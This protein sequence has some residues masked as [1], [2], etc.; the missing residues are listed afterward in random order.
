MSAPAAPGV[1]LVI[2][3]YRRERVLV[4]TVRLMLALD[5]TPDEI[6]IVDQT[7]RHEPDTEAELGALEKAGRIRW[8]RIEKPSIPH[9]MNVG[10]LEARHEI[11]L[12]TDDDVVPDARLIAAHLIAHEDPGVSVVAGRVYQLWDRRDRPSGAFFTADRKL[13]ATEFI[14]CNVSMKRSPAL[15]TGG[16]DEN[17][18]KAAYRYEAEF[19]WRSR[20]AGRSM[21]YEPD[22]II[23]HLKTTA[24]GTRSHGQPWFHPGHGV[25]EHYFLIRTRSL[26]G[27]IAGSSRRIARSVMTRRHLR[28][29]W[30]IPVTLAAEMTA[31]LWALLLALRGPRLLAISSEPPA[32][33]CHCEEPEATKQS[34]KMATL[35]R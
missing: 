35:L 16:F 27:T 19:S 15:A 13:P 31:F 1:T 8:I 7:P 33:G 26:A 20:Q 25:G 6:I 12:F 29:P 10:L 30:W 34:Q 5:P 22:A 14:G 11:V 17:F 9:A 18:V 32:P 4:E 3:T 23:D 28:A 24:G 21:V 2:P